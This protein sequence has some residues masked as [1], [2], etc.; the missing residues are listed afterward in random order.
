MA[1]DLIGRQVHQAAIELLQAA[2]LKPGQI[3]VVGGSTSEVLGYRMGTAGNVEVAV[4]LLSNILQVASEF[5][6]EMAVQCCEHLNRVLV[7]EHSVADQYGLEVVSVIPLPK[8]GGALAAT[9]FE[10]FR[11][12]VVVERIRAHA[13]IDIGGTLIG[14]H[15]R[16]VAV[17]VHSQVKQIGAAHLTMACTRPKLVGGERA[18]YHR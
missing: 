4:Q 11:D 9:A 5:R 2:N 8:A 14:M 6:V 7:V 1:F 10:V 3:L 16:P 15:L 12:P 18:E 13:G 17:R